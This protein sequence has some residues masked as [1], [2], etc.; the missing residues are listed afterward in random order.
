MED[1]IYSCHRNNLQSTAIRTD[2][3]IA[4]FFSYLDHWSTVTQV[5]DERRSFLSLFCRFTGRIGTQ[6]TAHCPVTRNLPAETGFH[7]LV[8]VVRY[9]STLSTAS[10]RYLSVHAHTKPETISK[11]IQWMLTLPWGIT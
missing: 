8:S 1:E 2:L 3:S 6:Q 9:A 7:P 10:G 4:I 5:N 11:F